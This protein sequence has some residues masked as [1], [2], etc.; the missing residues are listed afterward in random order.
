MRL[1]VLTPAEMSECDRRTIAAGP[2]DGYGLMLRA[3]QAVASTALSRYPGASRVDVL[4]G[5]GNNGGDGYVVAEILR[6]SGIEVALFAEGSPKKGTDAARARTDCR[7]EPRPLAEYAPTK[8]NLVVDAIF[9]AGLDRPVSGTVMRAIE[10]TAEARAPVLAVDLP[11]GVS[12]ETGKIL[13]TAFSAELTV[14]FARLK[15]GHLLLPG[16][17]N[18]G[19]V[20]VAD[21]GIPDS[22]VASVGPKCFENRPDLWRKTLPSWAVD[23]HKYSRGHVAAFSGG[24]SATGAVRLSALAAARAGAG[25][26]TLLSPS[27][28]LLV[29]AAH[30]TSIMLRRCDSGVEALDFISDRRVRAIVFGPGLAPEEPTAAMLRELLGAGENPA[31]V[32]DASAITALALDPEG[33]FEVSAAYEGPLVLTPHEGEFARLFPDLAAQSGS[34]L[35]RARLAAQRA[36][37]VVLLKGPDTVIAS[38]DGRAAINFNGTP[39]LATAGSGDVLSGII[40]GLLAQGMPA[41]EAA[42]AAAWMHAEAARSLG[43]G[44]I[45]D[46][47]PGALP[48][49]LGNLEAGR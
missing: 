21:I 2:L 16:R 35:E 49:V 41:F 15:P 18:C 13:G 22:V 46:D 24:P 19:E 44:L 3:G 32:V 11:S 25:A 9:G 12:G 1:E 26:V 5:P 39:L 33:F 47:L 36:S 14:T 42:C 31:V 30:L 28:A 40:A 45:A 10:F 17:T 48:G 8:G 23:V 20:I 6:R 37:A 34:K 38:P 27:A 29:N 7:I 43:P 4:C